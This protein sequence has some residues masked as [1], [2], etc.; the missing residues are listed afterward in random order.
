MFG[1]LNATVLIAAVAA[2]IPLVIHLFFRRR[3][4]VIEFSSLRHLKAMQRRQV[5]RLKIRQLL[6]LLLRMLIIFTVVLAF[7]RPTTE[8]GRVGSHASV[9]AVVL[10]DNSASMSRYVTDGKLIELARQRTEQLLE[11]FGEADDVCLVALDRTQEDSE[12]PSFGSPARAVEKLKRLQAGSGEADLQGALDNAKNLLA[13]AASLNKEIYIITDRQRHSLP[14]R[15]VLADGD[16]RI[17]LVDLPLEAHGNLGITAVDFGGQ[18]LTPGHDFEVAAIV[19]N[20]ANEEHSNVIAS[21]FLNDNRIAQ[22]DFAVGATSETVVRF[23]RAVSR[24][25]FHSGYVEISDDKFM[26]DNRYYFSF[27]IPERFNILIV[28]GSEAGRF[29]SLALVPATSSNQYWSVKQTTPEDLPGVNFFDYDA[30]ILDGVPVLA[31]SYVKRLKSFAGMGKALFLTY[32]GQT[33]IEYFNTTWSSLAGVVFDEPARKDFSRAGYYTFKSVDVDH[34]IFS[35]FGFERNQPPEIKFY[36]LPRLHLEDNAR[37]LLLFSGDRPALIESSY[38]G[39]RVLTFSGP[40]SPQYSDLTGHAF[41]VPF[42]SRVAEYLAADL[43]SYDLHLFVGD[44]ITRSLSIRGAVETSLEMTAPDSSV[45][46]LLPEEEENALVLRARPTGQAGLYRV[47]YLGREIDRFA[48][49]IN[50]EECDLDETDTDEFA[51]AIGVDDYRLLETDRELAAAVAELRFGKE[52]WQLFL[53]L[54]AVFIIIEILL[55]RGVVSED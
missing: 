33:D 35:V 30:V 38:L 32:D 14:N 23:K 41:F 43:S 48:V 20:Y 44:N 24:T 26:A 8:S 39:G 4:K 5:R 6:L 13:E 50:P 37:T 19:K 46:S 3:V 12:Q 49:N 21:L 36:T 2:L 18:L 22:T 42:I 52:L 9:A 11:T 17:Y 51:R 53:W 40:I 29:I 16:A 55:S 28:S 1:F 27:R 34:P 15:P 10:F 47:S 54:A 25:G 45:Y 7:A 31:D